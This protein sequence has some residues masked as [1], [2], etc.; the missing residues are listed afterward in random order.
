MPSLIKLMPIQ[1]TLVLSGDSNYLNRGSLLGLIA[2]TIF[3]SDLAFSGVLVWH[4]C[5]NN[6]IGKWK[7]A[8]GYV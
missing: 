1:A 6:L 8:I 5:F 2:E 4:C 7:S 3:S